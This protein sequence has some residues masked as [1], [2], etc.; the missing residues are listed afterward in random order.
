[1]QY[2]PLGRTGLPVSRVAF[3]AGPV[4]GLMTGQDEHAQEATLASALKAGINWI[5]TAAGYGQGKSEQNLGRVLKE[6]GVRTASPETADSVAVELR[7][8]QDPGVHKVL[9]VAT[10]VRVTLE[11]NEDFATQVKRSVEAS[12][13][14]L[15]LSHITL[16]QLHN[17]ITEARGSEP[18]SVTPDD[19][20]QTNGILKAMSELQSQG[21]VRYF[22]LTGTGEP[23]A[24]REVICSGRFDTVQLPYNML[25]PSA[26][27]QMPESFSE[28]NYGNILADCRQQNLGVFAIRVYA[29]GAL[30]GQQPS[31]HTLTTPFFPLDL[32][33]RD[34]VRAQEL[35]QQHGEA[36][37]A[38]AA[39]RE[40]ALR[41]ALS[42]PAVHSAII[43]FGSPDHIPSI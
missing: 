2:I 25:N 4:S 23:S 13:Q 35:R 42:H 24:M 29:G 7:S 43:G 6:L 8:R 20:L 11:S 17:G 10:K 16:L 38:A 40:E 5:D 27:Q 3:G 34:A 26:G 15:G 39:L 14:R 30:L 21:L 9:H 1:M 41:F 33:Q 31:A 12:L 28:R 32:Y 18:F 36:T 37:Q 22:G 19:V